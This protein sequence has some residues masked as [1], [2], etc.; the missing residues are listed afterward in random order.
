MPV[1]VIIQRWVRYG[2]EAEL[3]RALEQMRVQ[4]LS[5]SGYVSGETLRSPSDP[6]LWVVVS[7]WET[8]ADWENWA[9]GP[10][11]GEF[12]SRIAHLVAQPTQVLVLESIAVDIPPRAGLDLKP[13]ILGG[14]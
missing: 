12:E 6:S 10:D 2:R 4:A 8:L 9:H 13:E 7:T 1:R 3:R 5:Q 11:R 14:A